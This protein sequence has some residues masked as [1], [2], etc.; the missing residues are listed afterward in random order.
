ML[1]KFLKLI[2]QAKHFLSIALSIVNAVLKA[3]AEFSKEPIA[4]P[5]AA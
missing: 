4:A 1:K 2:K 3:I 5:E